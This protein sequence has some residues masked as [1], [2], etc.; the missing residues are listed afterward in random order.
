MAAKPFRGVVNL[1]VRDSVPDCGDGL[2]AVVA[3][4]LFAVLARPQ[5]SPYLIML[6]SMPLWLAIVVTG[7]G[8][9][10]EQDAVANPNNP[11][12][13]DRSPESI[14]IHEGH[15]SHGRG[16]SRRTVLLRRRFLPRDGR[17]PARS[18]R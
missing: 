10:H 17:Y 5:A 1:D 3:L 11:V 14:T 8:P 18:T 7:S 6:R 12:H 9:A 15:R 2:V 4:T 16:D 13:R